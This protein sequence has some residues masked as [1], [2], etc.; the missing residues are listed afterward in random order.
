MRH[1]RSPRASARALALLTAGCA[2]TGGLAG[3][4]GSTHQATQSLTGSVSAAAAGPAASTGAP[5]SSSAAAA[6]APASDSGSQLKV[7]GPAATS[8]HLE[9]AG[10]T[11]DASWTVSSCLLNG[12]QLM[13]AFTNNSLINDSANTASDGLLALRA[14]IADINGTQDA[15]NVGVTATLSQGNQQSDAVMPAGKVTYSPNGTSS[16]ELTFSGTTTDGKPMSGKVTCASYLN[17]G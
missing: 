16:G 2:L 9:L 1:P 14:M 5:A 11:Y 6:P 17:N 4:G 3:C 13:I 10:K 12:K 7:S 8:V 15:T